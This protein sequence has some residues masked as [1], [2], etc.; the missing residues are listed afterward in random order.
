MFLYWFTTFCIELIANGVHWTPLPNIDFVKLKSSAELSII[1]TP[2]FIAVL[3]KAFPK[4]SL[5]WAFANSFYPLCIKL[6]ANT[7]KNNNINKSYQSYLRFAEYKRL[8]SGSIFSLVKSSLT[9]F[10]PQFSRPW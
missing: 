6:L 3:A 10:N 7:P 2:R 4:F 5:E 1:P 9:P 8:K